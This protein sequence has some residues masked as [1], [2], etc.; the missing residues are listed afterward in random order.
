MAQSIQ[1]RILTAIEE[2]ITS[3]NYD[4]VITHEGSDGGALF[5]QHG[6]HTD[7]VIAFHLW[8]AGCTFTLGGPLVDQSDLKTHQIPPPRN[9]AI[10]SLIKQGFE[11]TYIA[12]DDGK[13]L[14]QLIA[15]ISKLL[16]PTT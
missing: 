6:L 7:L 5:A 8:E 1:N 11:F 13:K 12:Y 16:T 2:V 14:E 9:S 10:G 15:T 4:A 3:A